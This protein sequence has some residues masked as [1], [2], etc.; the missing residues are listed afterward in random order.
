[1]RLSG[2]F[3]SLFVL[4]FAC[5][6]LLAVQLPLLGAYARM[7]GEWLA[8]LGVTQVAAAGLVLGSVAGGTAAGALLA[9]AGAGLVKA[10]LGRQSGNDSYA[11][12]L[13]VGWSGALLLAANAAR[14]EELSHALLE[15]QIYFT[16]PLDVGTLSVLLVVTVALLWRLSRR[17]L[18]GCLQPDR[19]GADGGLARW[20]DT[21]FD[22]LLAVSL[23]LAATVVGVMAAF[24]LV[25]VPA[26]VAFR[27]AAGWRSTL[28]W[29][30]GLGLVAYM[31]SFA[32]A[33][34]FDQP[35]GPVLVATLLL[36]GL[37]RTIR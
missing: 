12:M 11:V 22:V 15:G 13:L 19:L 17:L 1:V 7:R 34:V 20:H 2:L 26:W 14:G 28:A 16:R 9:A 23:A 18:L 6:L 3:D 24:A 35:Y 27:L 32:M 5:G 33:I 29:S 30:I 31:S 37:G 10:M 36:V 21:V 8:S 4:P 25:F